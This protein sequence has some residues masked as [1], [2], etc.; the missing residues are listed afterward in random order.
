MNT[1][2]AQVPNHDLYSGETGESAMDMQMLGGHT[3]AAV[4]ANTSELFASVKIF[5]HVLIATLNA[6]MVQSL[7]FIV[8]KCSKTRIDAI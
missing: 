3:Y 2:I 4:I 5:R 8:S 6:A 7:A 1:S